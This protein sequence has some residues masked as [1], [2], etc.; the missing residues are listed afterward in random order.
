MNN[1]KNLFM[2]ISSFVSFYVSDCLADTLR[3]AKPVNGEKTA[4]PKIPESELSGKQGETHKHGNNAGGEEDFNH[5]PRDKQT[6]PVH[7]KKQ[8]SDKHT[9]LV[10]DRNP[11]NNDYI[12][13]AGELDDTQNLGTINSLTLKNSPAS[14]L[15]AKDLPLVMPITGMNGDDFDFLEGRWKF[16]KNFVDEKGNTVRA[17]FEF[18]VSGAGLGFLYDSNNNVY[19][20]RVLAESDQNE[21]KIRSSYF[22]DSEGRKIY[23]PLYVD[24]RRN[25][26]SLICDGSDGWN[27]WTN[28]QLVAVDKRA[29]DS[30]NLMND[31]NKQLLDERGVAESSFRENEEYVDWDN[32]AEQDSLSNAS[33][34][35]DNYEDTGSEAASLMAELGEG[36]ELPDFLQNDSAK[37]DVSNNNLQNPLQGNWRLSKTFVRK[38]DGGSIVLEFH[39]DDDGKGYSLIKDSIYGDSKA[40]ARVMAMKDGTYR[41]KTDSYKGSSSYYPTFMLCKPD[42]KKE[43]HCDVSNGWLH[44]DDGLLLSQNSFDTNDL[45]YEKLQNYDNKQITEKSQNEGIGNTDSSSESLIKS[46]KQNN[47]SGNESTEDLLAGLSEM[48]AGYN[49]S[50]KS[51]SESTEDML[52]K[53]S[54]L[55][56]SSDRNTAKRSFGDTDIKHTGKSSGK[57]SGKSENKYLSLPKNS[58]GFDFLEG[59]W[60]CDAGLVANFNSSEPIVFEFK[61]DKTGKGGADLKVKGRNEVYRGAVKASYDKKHNLVINT[62]DFYDKDGK[63]KFE[64]QSIT[65]KPSKGIALCSGVNVYS[66]TTW[67]DVHFIRIK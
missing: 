29:T 60:L 57:S 38:G 31:I 9:P 37:A 42:S 15:S 21:L 28:Q 23:Y 62:S 55:S 41:V 56:E 39:F 61:F 53:L 33:E 65:C 66:K 8:F 63:I 24:C 14:K 59:K 43:L 52:A 54:E 22:K 46:E 35:P 16:D 64:G 17:E 47:Q 6:L 13:E 49:S 4:V 40:N 26:K 51:E 45:E 18:E 58:N 10:G 11:K 50:T 67:S 3:L 20:G 36:Y 32:F 7:S 19:V 2:I 44:V 5:V 25:N 12:Y 27:K 30:I 48:G 34:M 1:I